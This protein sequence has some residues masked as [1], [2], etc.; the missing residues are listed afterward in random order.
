M[1]SPWLEVWNN[2]L[3]QMMKYLNSAPP[4]SSPQNTLSSLKVKNFASFMIKS[5]NYIFLP[6]ILLFANKFSISISESHEY[7]L[8]PG[9]N[10]NQILKCQEKRNLSVGVLLLMEWSKKSK[11]NCTDS[12]VLHLIIT[13][14]INKCC[15]SY[16]NIL[17]TLYATIAN[18]TAN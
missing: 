6:V 9:R 8:C 7:G 17:S 12:N 14:Y 15:K 3:H 16:K 1:S 5:M 10:S 4:E 18:F 2:L 11:K 13:K